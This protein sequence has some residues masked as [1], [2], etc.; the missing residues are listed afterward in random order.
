M[1]EPAH[2]SYGRVRKGTEE[3]GEGDLRNVMAPVQGETECRI[4][5]KLHSSTLEKR[6]NQTDRI[7]AYHN[8]HGKCKY[9]SVSDNRKT[10][11]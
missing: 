10:E 7:L 2:E 4:L 3:Y 11:S 5:L 1:F 9:G 8:W 6:L